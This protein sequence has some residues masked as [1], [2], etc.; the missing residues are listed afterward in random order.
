M[1]AVGLLPSFVHVVPDCCHGDLILTTHTCTYVV[2]VCS[3]G[4]VVDGVRVS[5]LSGNPTCFCRRFWVFLLD[6]DIPLVRCHS[7]PLHL[8]QP[9]LVDDPSIDISHPCARQEQLRERVGEPHPPSDPLI[10]HLL[11]LERAT[12][13]SVFRDRRPADDCERYCL[14]KKMN[15]A[16]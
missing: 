11:L 14:Q 2:H 15:P 16:N 9:L 1:R 6:W 13:S 12:L 3:A 10:W 8:Q 7:E 5:I 4:G